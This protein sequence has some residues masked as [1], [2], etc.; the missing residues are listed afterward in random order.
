MMF[1][2]PR[3]TPAR[4]MDVWNWLA[5]PILISVGA[6]LVMALPLRVFGFSAPEPVFAMVPAFA[7]ALVRPSILPP[8]LLMASGLLLDVLWGAPLGLWG[9][10]LLAGYAAVLITRNFASGQGQAMNWVWYAMT[11]MVVELTAYLTT[12]VDT[13]AAPSLL[14]AFWQWGATA[15]LYPFAHRL[16]ERF[17]D[18]DVRFK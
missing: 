15:A 10:S 8:L 3:S 1:Q 9:F 2:P 5:V 7:W 16:I 11:A 12:L 14:G 4:S 6:T 13:H 17:D 18:A